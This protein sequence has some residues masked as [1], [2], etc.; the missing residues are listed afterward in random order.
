MI[1]R[2]LLRTFKADAEAALLDVAKK[3]NVQI[4]F[5]NGSFTSENATLKLEIATI[6]TDG[7][8][9]TKE[10]IDFERYASRYGLSPEDLGTIFVYNGT[11]Y[12]L[13]GAKPRSTKYPLLAKNVKSGKVY[14]VPATA[15]PSS[16]G[17]EVPG[18]GLTEDAKKNFV[19]LA[20]NLSPENLSCDGELPM[21]Q[22]RKRRASL[23][24][25]WKSLEQ[26]VGRFVSEDEVW[27][28]A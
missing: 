6:G 13:I 24:R 16:M 4:S 23:N 17:K 10:A 12:K 22:V 20:C 25:E 8:A 7:E 9:K 5:G 1:T 15:I 19:R 26:T 18:F 28:W 14:K 27:S 21:A 11:E 2:S 3:H